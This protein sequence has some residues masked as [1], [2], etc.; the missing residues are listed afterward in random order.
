MGSGKTTVGNLLAAR[1]G[2]PFVDNDVHL[3]ART[4]CSAR[5]IA[6]AEGADGL[7]RHEA[8]ALVDALG[9]SVPSVI[10][11]AA[12]APAAPGVAAALRDHDVVYLHI[13]PAVLADRLA[14]AIDDGHRP[15]VEHDAP[16]VLAAQ[17]AARDGLYRARADVTVEADRDTP[18]VVV[19]E[20]SSALARRASRTP[21]G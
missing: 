12:A 9:G 10:A 17:Y 4:G 11:A 1:L 19:D 14:G 2:R 15:F 18:A 6:A 13:S 5:E 7:H 3:L 16:S 21:P 8:E 20:I